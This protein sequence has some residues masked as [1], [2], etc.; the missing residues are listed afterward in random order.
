MELEYV[1]GS[2]ET[3][4]IMK[5][6]AAFVPFH[7]KIIDFLDEMSKRLLKSSKAK[8]YQDVIAFAFWCRK[9]SLIEMKKNI[10]WLPSAREKGVLGRGIVFHVAPSNVAM[11]FAYSFVAGLLAGNANIVRLPSKKFPQVDCFCNVLKEM[12]QELE[13]WKSY[14]CFVRY[15]HEKEITD[16][17]SEISDVRVIWGGDVTIQEIRKSPLKIRG[18]EIVFSDRYSIGVI[19]AKYFLLLSKEQKKRIAQGFYND[20]YLMDQNACTSPMLLVWIG[21]QNIVKK[22]QKD[23]WDIVLDFVQKKYELQ[24]VQAV[25]KL[26]AL[27]R[28]AAAVPG[29]TL[30]SFEDIPGKVDNRIVRVRLPKLSFDSMNYKENSG[31]FMEYITEKLEDILPICTSRCQTISFLGEHLENDLRELVKK[32]CPSGVDRI[33]PMGKT[34]NFSLIWDGYDLI[35]EMSRELG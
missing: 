8:Q 12:L 23:F 20:T 9:A 13:E 28:L 1:L 14:L 4:E 21:I 29:T 15:G 17:L 6:K 16:M 22:A 11:N 18:K 34:L 5:K 19:D 35:R 2:K 10:A 33:V 25:K 26:Q 31:F 7:E 32:Y 27:Y 3:L 24:P 30:S